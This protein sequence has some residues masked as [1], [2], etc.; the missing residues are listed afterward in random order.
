M[1]QR[2]DVLYALELV[3]KNRPNEVFDEMNKSEVGF[4]AVIKYLYESSIDVTSADICKHLKI[5]SA[6]MA[7]LIKKLEKKGLVVKINSDKDARIKVLKLSKKGTEFAHKMKAHMYET[8]KKIIDEFGL[9]EIEE[10]FSKLSRLK[11]IMKENLPR[12]LGEYND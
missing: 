5:S 6:R 9:D 8:M 4:F 3:H 10:L 12:N 11:C 7:V 2:D 1:T